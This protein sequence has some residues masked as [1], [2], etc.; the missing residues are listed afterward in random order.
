MDGIDMTALERRARRDPEVRTALRTIKR[1]VSA[2][3][4]SKSQHSQLEQ[5]DRQS[6][7][8][9]HSRRSPEDRRF[10][11]AWNHK[12]PDRVF[13][14]DTRR[15]SLQEVQGDPSYPW[16][17]N[18][19]C[20]AAH[21]VMNHRNPRILPDGSMAPPPT[22]RTGRTATARSDISSVQLYGVPKIAPN[23]SVGQMDEEGLVHS[24]WSRGEKHGRESTYD[25][26]QREGTH[27]H[28]GFVATAR[29]RA[30]PAPAFIDT[31]RSVDSDIGNYVFK[32]GDNDEMKMPV[33]LR[34]YN[35]EL[36]QKLV[37][38]VVGDP[39]EF[40]NQVRPWKANTQDKAHWLKARAKGDLSPV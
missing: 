37:K 9:Q 40:G 15:E 10:S 13:G 19:S 31:A 4:K 18:T 1:R 27:V 28:P 22:A 11:S 16:R 35:Q 38:D 32:V 24:S 12:A 6:E 14:E 5:S 21:G 34:S 36:K 20:F 25:T 33:Q 39:S 3:E 26:L 8:S 2:I 17:Y 23:R 29:R 30:A 7:H